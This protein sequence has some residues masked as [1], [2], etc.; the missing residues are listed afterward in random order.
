[1][2]VGIRPEA[3]YIVCGQGGCKGW[4]PTKQRIKP[5][6]FENAIK[7]AKKKKI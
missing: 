6:R 5:N 7:R 2:A 4:T 1:M 3:P